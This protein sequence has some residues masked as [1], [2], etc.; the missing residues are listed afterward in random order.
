M[1]VAKRGNNIEIEEIK[2]RGFQGWR[3]VGRHLSVVCTSLGGQIAAIFQEPDDGIN[4]LWQ[5][6]WPSAYPGE[7]D[8]EIYGCGEEAQLL[9][10]IVGSFP[11]IDRFGPPHPGEIKPV[12]GEA[13]HAL[14]EPDTQPSCQERDFCITA[15]L[16]QAKLIVQRILRLYRHTLVLETVVFNGSLEEKEIEWCEHLTI[17]DPFLDGAEIS[18]AADRAYAY[19]ETLQTP[20]RFPADPPL[21]KRV[22][23]EVLSLPRRGDPPSGDIYT[24]PMKKGWIRITHPGLRKRFSICWE[25]SDFPWLC[26]WNENCAQQEKPWNGRTRSCGLEISTKPFPEGK[27]PSERHPTFLGRSTTC[28][29]PRLSAGVTKTIRMTWKNLASYRGKG[30]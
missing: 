27:P 11:C 7:G 20:S 5:P 25:V 19:P 4:P 30:R 29:L 23:R 8:T 16:P 28:V 24:M 10:G 1:I 12:H 13:T 14:W 2:W 15:C 3:L 17:G 21:A 26:L 9:Q 18:A 22:A 6:P